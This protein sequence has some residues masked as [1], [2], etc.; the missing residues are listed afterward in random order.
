MTVEFN[1]G[2]VVQ[3]SPLHG[4]IVEAKTGGPND[5][6]RDTVRSTQPR[7]VTGVG[8]DLG[9]NQGYANHNEATGKGYGAGRTLAL[10]LVVVRQ[11]DD[12]VFAQ[13]VTELNLDQYQ[14]LV[15]TV[16][17]SMVG[18]CRQVDVGPFFQ[19]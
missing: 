6:Q 7:N 1:L 14:R 17:Q 9:F 2:P 8:R 10:S 3:A 15:R 5:V 18:F 13:V 19:L 16:S 12:I 11:P 4:A